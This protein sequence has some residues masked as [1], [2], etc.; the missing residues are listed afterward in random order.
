MTEQDP[1]QNVVPFEAAQSEQL[2]QTK[3]LQKR[4][5][6]KTPVDSDS[7]TED[8]K[9]HVQ[10]LDYVV[11]GVVALQG[12]RHVMPFMSFLAQYADRIYPDIKP[13]RR[14]AMVRRKHKGW[15]YVCGLLDGVLQLV[16]VVAVLAGPLVL[17]YV[18]LKQTLGF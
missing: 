5:K 15:I 10:G 6:R 17:A 7:D 4:V 8:A 12:T 2:R 18:G 9:G 13:E 1:E 14:M 3:D 11:P 16:L